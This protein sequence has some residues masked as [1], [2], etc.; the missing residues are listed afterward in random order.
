MPSQHG[1]PPAKLTDQP[2]SEVLTGETDLH[3]LLDAILGDEVNTVAAAAPIPEAS[4]PAI[5]VDQAVSPDPMTDDSD[6]W[7]FVGDGAL[8]DEIDIES[9]HAV[10]AIPDD[11]PASVGHPVPSQRWRGIKAVALSRQSVIVATLLGGALLAVGLGRREARQP[12]PT[13]LPAGAPVERASA[14]ITPPAAGPSTPLSAVDVPQV[15]R[16]PKKNPRVLDSTP[17]QRPNQKV[18][19]RAGAAVL[20]AVREAQEPTSPPIPQQFASPEPVERTTEA[21]GGVAAPVRVSANAAAETSPPQP[22]GTLSSARAANVVEAASVPAVPVPVAVPR[23]TEPRRL[24]GGAPEY[25]DALRTARIGGSVE[26]RFTIDAGGRVVNVRSVTGPRQLRV[27]AEAA[28][29][30]WRYQPGRVGDVAVATE[31]SVN[32]N[33]DPATA[34]RSQQ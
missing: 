31:T 10:A 2:R 5:E 21:S 18:D 33:F 23:R 34:R 12:L 25:P 13:P 20:P 26:V 24:A 3:A 29:R 11:L 17:A 15:D 22:A 1:V 32:F 4:R 6:A 19:E 9:K 27:V 28:V 8:A 30:G 7:G 16:Q 14:P